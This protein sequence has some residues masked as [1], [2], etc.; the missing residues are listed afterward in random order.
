MSDR[1]RTIVWPQFGGAIRALEQAI[2]ACP[3]SLWGDVPGWHVFSYLAFHTLW[4]LDHYLSGAGD[5]HVPPAPFGRE[6]LDPNGTLPPRSYTREELLAYLEYDWRRC[7][8]RLAAMTDADAAAPSESPRQAETRGELLLYNLRHVQHH[9]GQL[10]LLL[11]QHGVEPP[12]WV[13]RETAPL[14]P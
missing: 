11:R 14:E 5:D 2:R 13:R 4:W 1:F 10:Q 6:E 12:R 9:T 7:R 3:D 8:A